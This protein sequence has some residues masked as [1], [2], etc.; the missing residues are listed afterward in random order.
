M[1]ESQKKYTGVSREPFYRNNKMTMLLEEMIAKCSSLEEFEKLYPEEF[2]KEDSR[3][4]DYLMELLIIYNGKASRISE[5][6]GCASGYVGHLINGR[7]KNPSRNVLISI[8]L[9][10]GTTVEEVQYLLKY[11]GHQP[12]YVRRKR[13]VIIWY[14]FMKKKTPAEVND[15]LYQRGY[16]LLY[17]EK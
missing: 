14:G 12:L 6:A 15:N 10:L 16:P 13:D 8:C 9:A 3:L 17:K 11:A 5:A 1:N 4:Q 2:L 7:V